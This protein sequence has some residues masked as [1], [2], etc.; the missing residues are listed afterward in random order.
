MNSADDAFI[1][2]ENQNLDGDVYFDEERAYP[3]GAVTD[4][5]H[6]LAQARDK[7]HVWLAKQVDDA[8]QECGEY[9][10][11]EEIEIEEDEIQGIFEEHLNDYWRD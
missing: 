8:R 11:E 6:A 3:R 10:D 1:W 5:K 9:L 2:V 4:A 7:T